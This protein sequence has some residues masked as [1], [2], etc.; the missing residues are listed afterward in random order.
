[1]GLLN[2]NTEI[3]AFKVY[4]DR[5]INNAVP[6]TCKESTAHDYRIILRKHIMPEFAEK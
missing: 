1:M 6:V 2:E 3:P 5:W 4:A